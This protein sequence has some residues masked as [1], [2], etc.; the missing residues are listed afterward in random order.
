MFRNRKFTRYSKFHWKNWFNKSIKWKKICWWTIYF[1][2]IYTNSFNSEKNSE[3]LQS[4][5]SKEFEIQI[6]ETETASLYKFEPK[7]SLNDTFIFEITHSELTNSFDADQND[8]NLDREYQG[9][10]WN[11][12]FIL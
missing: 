12:E 3:Y 1:I 9:I 7:S 8:E 5:S 11:S 2:S 4:F 10:H 6:G